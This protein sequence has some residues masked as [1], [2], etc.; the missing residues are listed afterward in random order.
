LT[1][2][3]AG[4]WYRIAVVNLKNRDEAVQCCRD[5]EKQGLKEWCIYT[6]VTHQQVKCSK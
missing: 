5:L 3:Q 1:I 2:K 4:K 6:E